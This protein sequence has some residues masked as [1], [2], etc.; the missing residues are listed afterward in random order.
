MFLL[1]VLLTAAP[2]VIEALAPSIPN[3]KIVRWLF[4]AIERT[5]FS[6]IQVLN[7]SITRLREHANYDW[8]N[9]RGEW[10]FGISAD[11]V[12]R[13]LR[14]LYERN[15]LEIANSLRKPALL[16]FDAGIVPP[17]KFYL[18]IDFLGPKRLNEAL[19]EFSSDLAIPP[20]F[21]WDGKER[22]RA[23]VA[24][25]PARRPIDDK[26]LCQLV[27]HGQA[28]PAFNA[29]PTASVTTRTKKA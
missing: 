4:V 1:A 28:F 17:Q 19:R 29:S 15:K 20:T 10:Q 26:H 25:H 21:G 11:E 27:S 5:N 9:G 6:V 8:Q 24:D 7:A 13:R 22:R 16:A 2:E 18:L 12:G 14:I 3:E 23:Q